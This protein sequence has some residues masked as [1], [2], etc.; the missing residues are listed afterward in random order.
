MSQ[1]PTFVISPFVPPTRAQPKQLSLSLISG[2]PKRRDLLSTSRSSRRVLSLPRTRTTTTTSPSLR[3][4]TRRRSTTSTL[5]S[6]LT[7]E[8]STSP[9]SCALL[10]LLLRDGTRPDRTER[11]SDL[12]REGDEPRSDPSDLCIFFLPPSAD[13]SFPLEF[14]I[15]AEEGEPG[16]ERDEWIV[17]LVSTRRL[18]TGH[19]SPSSRRLTALSPFPLPSRSTPRPTSPPPSSAAGSR[20]LS[21]T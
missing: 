1:A 9:S 6:G 12:I 2:S 5:T 18:A 4:R 8:H 21:T 16:F 17:G 19:F 3:R 10:V 13:L 11:V 20:T 15:G 14:G 7:R